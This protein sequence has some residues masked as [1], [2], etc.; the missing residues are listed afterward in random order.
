MGALSIAMFSGITLA[1]I[2]QV[3]IAENQ[4]DLAGCGDRA[5]DFGKQRDLVC[6]R[7]IELQFARRGSTAPGLVPSA[8][9]LS[10]SPCFAVSA[11]SATA[12][13]SATKTGKPSS[14]LAATLSGGV[15]LGRVSARLAW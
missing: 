1:L 8:E 2:A 6:A 13:K 10:R 5:C 15:D 12:V 4:C 14:A 11:A 7:D 9:W 3:R